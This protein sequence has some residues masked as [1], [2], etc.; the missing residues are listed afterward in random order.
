MRFQVAR[1]AMLEAL[2]AVVPV[3]ERRLPQPILSNVLIEG[4]SDGLRFTATDQELELSVLLENAEITGFG[5]MTVPARKL[6]EIIRSLPGNA[7]V[8]MFEEEA[9]V[10]L[11]SGRFK[12]HLATLPANEFPKAQAETEVVSFKVAGDALAELIGKCRFAMAQQDVRYFFNGMLV[13]LDS[14]QVRVVATN[15]QRLATRFLDIEHA[16]SGKHQFIIPRKGVLELERLIA[17]LGA[18]DVR[19]GF[20]GNSLSVVAGSRRLT[21]RLVDGTYPDYT[22][23]IPRGGDKVLVGDRRAIRDALARA[24]ILS[25]ELYRNVRLKMSQDGLEV[26]ASNPLQEEAEEFVDAEY[27]GGDLEIGFNVTYLMDVLGVMDGDR[28][29]M[30]FSDQSSAMLMTQEADDRSQFVVSPMML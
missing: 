2:Q 8:D 14:G 12:S 13:E 15:G 4:N 17:G 27:E 11:E 20:S 24:S 10:G 1:D 19:L 9:R 6:N 18:G 23:A 28:V 16:P 22:R 30:E 26:R 5:A 7:L 25:N 21:S 3:V 29:R